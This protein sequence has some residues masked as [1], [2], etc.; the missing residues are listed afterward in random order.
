VIFK[1]EKKIFR[2]KNSSQKK[3]WRGRTPK[4]KYLPPK[5]VKKRPFNPK[6]K[7]PGLE[8]N[9]KK[10]SRISPKDLGPDSNGEA[11]EISGCFGIWIW[12]EMDE[13][14]TPASE[15]CRRSSEVQSRM[16]L[17]SSKHKDEW[18]WFGAGCLLLASALIYFTDAI[19]SRLRP[20]KY[21]LC[22]SVARRRRFFPR[23]GR[24]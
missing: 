12:I 2:Q 15:E 23:R 22:W 18:G 24:I 21:N 1:K 17:K 9:S 16:S 14:E 13:D 4:G 11:I 5:E 3:F 20:V 10:D 7:K 8:N 6:P 19:L